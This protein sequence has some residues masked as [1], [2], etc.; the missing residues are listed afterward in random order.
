MSEKKGFTLI[1]LI[2]VVVILG[3]IALIAVPAVTSYLSGSQMSSYRMAEQSLAD[4][5]YNM[6]TDCAGVG[7]AEVCNQYSVP[8]P[9]DYVTVP[10]SV[11]IDNGFLN[12]IEDQFVMSDKQIDFD[13]EML[14]KLLSTSINELTY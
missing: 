1:E 11:L 5:A 8:D 10:L 14:A 7:E 2:A 12:P 9:N 3:I 13:I 6:F 4:A